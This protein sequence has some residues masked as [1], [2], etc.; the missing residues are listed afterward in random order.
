LESGVKGVSRTHAVTAVSFAVALVACGGG[1]GSDGMGS[2]PPADFNLQA[3]ITLSGSANVNGV[4]TPFTGTGTYAR[5]PA[6]SGTFNGA[7]AASQAETLSGTITVAG[8]STPYS[9]SVTD[10]YATGNSAFLGEVEGNEYDVAQSP[11]EY[12]TM[13]VGGS[14][15]VL[16]TVSRYT[17]KTMSVSLGT[18]QV[19]YTV[20]APVDPGSPIGITFTNKIYDT[21]NTLTE[22]DVT[23]YT[24]TSSNVIS[25]VSASV[26]SQSGTLTVTAQ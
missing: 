23:R 1:G 14:G 10:Y 5:A 21:Q 7:A 2:P 8:R 17:D 13:V 24:M 15:G 22:T 25:F 11:I 6:V 19:S 3:G 16:G 20:L 18:A 26:Q 4:S 9:S 12:P